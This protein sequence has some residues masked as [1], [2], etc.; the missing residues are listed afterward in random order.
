MADVA[1]TAA[2]VGGNSRG[3]RAIAFVSELV[4][5]Y[6]NIG[7]GTDLFYCK[8]TDGGKT[9]AAAVSL[10]TGTVDSFDIWYDQWTPGDTGK[11][12]HIA[13]TEN[14]TDDVSYFKLNTSTDV[15]T[16]IV[17]VFAGASAV[18]GRGTFTSITKARG[19]NLYVAFDMDAGAEMGLYR[20][21]DQ[22]ATWGS[23]TSPMEATL[24]QA[25]LFPAN[26]ADPNDI[27]MI[28]DDDSANELT[29]KTHD[30]SA[31]TNS[32]SSALTFTNENTDLTG[33]Y[34][35]SGSIRH[36][37]GHLIF[38]YFDAYDAAAASDLKV[39]DWDGTTLTALT[40]I[41]TNS[42]SM[43]YPSVYL[44]QDQPDW[45]FV[46]HL[47]VTAGTSTLTTSVPCVYALSKDRGQT[48]TKDIA[49]SSA[50]TDYRN[51]WA[52]LNGEV[53]YVTYFD[54]SG[55]DVMKNYEAAIPF[56]FTKFAN[57][58]RL[59]ATGYENDNI[60]SIGGNQ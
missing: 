34:G 4:G 15:V 2:T 12:L 14:G 20:S 38:A 51:T 41:A 21:V 7:A 47:G 58:L 5:Y 57:R 13:F 45:I 9:W 50:T 35:F 19:G 59:R 3:M 28:Y 26:A 30:D 22:G 27:W 24:D 40:D 46:A 6:V 49:Y 54:I 16:S 25:L 52:P 60:I 32:E 43:Y 39:Y 56:G 36:Q 11:M 8:T 17:D 23:R 55:T 42:D 18:L 33:Q 1:L 48:W 44:N 29:I 10:F 37:D 53:F 31:N